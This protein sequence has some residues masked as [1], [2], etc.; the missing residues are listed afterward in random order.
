MNLG[1]W[2]VGIVIAILILHVAAAWLW[3]NEFRNLII[4]VTLSS[5]VKCSIDETLG[6]VLLF[7]WQIYWV[8]IFEA[9]HFSGWEGKVLHF[10]VE[11]F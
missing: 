8:V 10:L 7:Y 11:L 1:G 4:D 6:S 9:L 5:T 2:R 3:A